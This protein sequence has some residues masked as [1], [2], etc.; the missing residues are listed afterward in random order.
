MPRFPI[1]R[2]D[3]SRL[4]ILAA[5]WAGLFLA[6]DPRGQFPLNDDF[7]YA[8]CARRWLG[9]GGL[10][11][12]EW[13]L[14]STISHALLGAVATA[15]WGATNQALRMWMLVLGLAGAGLAYAL[16]RRW[17]A[18][19]NDALLAALTL[20]V[21]PLYAALSASFHLDVTVAVFTLAGLWAFL[22]GRESGSLRW[23]AASSVLI[24]V[25]GLARQTGFLCAVGGAAALAL[26]RKLSARSA[27]ALLLPAG[28]AAFGFWSWFHF[29]HGTTWAWES[30]YY[31]PNSSLR[32]WVRL[33]VWGN[34]FARIS[35]TIQTGSLCLLPLAVLR[36]KD[37]AR[38]P[39]R[40]EWAAL[41]LLI[42]AAL[43]GWERAGG[44]PLIQ[45]TLSHLGLGVVTLMGSDDKPAGWWASPWL[46]NAAALLALASSIVLAQSAALAW[47]AGRTDEARAAVLFVA[48]PFGVVL[49][50]P[51][52]YDRYL[53]ALLPAAA[54]AG[55]ARRRD[56]ALAMIP[57]FAA[58][59]LLAA[60]TRA[61]LSD[62]FAWNRARWAAGMDAVARGVP[63]EKIE[64]GYD[65]NGQ[66]SLTRNLAILRR[67]HSAA[68]IG[69]WDWEMLNKI[70][71]ETTF[72][73]KP[74][75]EGWVLVAR[76][77]YRTPLVP[78]G[79]VVRVFALPA[80]VERRVPEGL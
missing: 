55:A 71:L 32:Y 74:T 78:G 56:K 70:V 24:A 61:G 38:R 33:D 49:L 41:S 23:L 20:A 28:L 54:A 34:V 6:V 46:W 75:E 40:G 1:R 29:I 80:I 37:A 72:S 10:H 17:G 50:M 35:K 68:G 3:A 13:A 36:W 62:Y 64:N 4:L 58:A 60:F 12:P 25:S 9:G 43:I 65:W 14:S 76:Y 53:L 79:G 21:S 19:A 39:T 2:E 69:L 15:P 18:G 59:A 26:D 31:S 47:R 48:V 7:Q 5:A 66:F 57:A 30:G 52:M 63:P 73:D 11:L 77:P 44:L 51:A 22:R 42:G 8:E 16:A 27:A 67:H 45:N